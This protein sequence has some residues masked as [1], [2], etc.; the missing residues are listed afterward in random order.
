MTFISPV[1][2]GVLQLLAWPVFAVGY[3]AFLKG[4]VAVK[5][6]FSLAAAI[7]AI[8]VYTLF[9][10]NAVL[11]SAVI[12]ANLCMAYA[13][14][15]GVHNYSRHTSSIVAITF[16]LTYPII[17]VLHKYA[18]AAS[19]QLEGAEITTVGVLETFATVDFYEVLLPTLVIYLCLYLYLAHKEARYIKAYCVVLVVCFMY[20]LQHFPWGFAAMVYLVATVYLLVFAWLACKLPR[21]L[22]VEGSNK[23]AV[24]LSGYSSAWF[25]LILLLS[26]VHIRL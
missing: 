24:C 6:L 3:Y 4:R 23:A 18:Y 11:L 10:H 1:V 14:A 5:A 25:S 15:L 16:L 2:W 8:G 20:S 9:Y 12:L 13:S 17:A 19:S 7:A 21:Y 26:S 22:D